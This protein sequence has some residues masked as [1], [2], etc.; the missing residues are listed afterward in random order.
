MTP[1]DIE[2]LRLAQGMKNVVVKQLVLESSDGEWDE[3][4]I[5]EWQ[6]LIIGGYED[7]CVRNGKE[8]LIGMEGDEERRVLTLFVDVTDNTSGSSSARSFVNGLAAIPSIS[9]NTSSGT[10]TYSLSS[11]DPYSTT[12]WQ[13]SLFNVPTDVFHSS[14]SNLHTNNNTSERRSIKWAG[15]AVRALGMR[16]WALAKNA[17]SADIFVV[18]LGYVLMHT[19]FVRLFLN[20]RKMGSS[21]WLRE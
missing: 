20:M 2:R 13:S 15:Y 19:T 18:L 5:Q 10:Y 3:Q 17:D 8:C 11:S 7:V 4:V 6:G 14:R 12:T 21:F 1:T 9:L 16:F